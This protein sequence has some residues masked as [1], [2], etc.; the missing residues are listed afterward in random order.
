MTTIRAEITLKA[1]IEILYF[2][3][4]SCSHSNQM[5]TRNTTRDVNVIPVVVDLDLEKLGS[6]AIGDR[7]YTVFKRFLD[8]KQVRPVRSFRW[9][10]C[11]V[12]SQPDCSRFF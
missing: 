7:E 8:C 2:F 3:A 10:D 9:Y 6:F 11:A 5:N 1:F 4:D 12:G